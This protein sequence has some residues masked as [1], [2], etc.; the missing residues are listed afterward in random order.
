MPTLGDVIDKWKA[1]D[2]LAYDEFKALEQKSKAM[3]FSMV[4]QTNEAFLTDV[5]DSITYALAEGLTIDDWLTS[6]EA[7]AGSYG[8]G[9]TEAEAGYL[10]T[11]F[12]TAW[13]S[14]MNGGKVSSMFSDER[15]AIAPYW[16]FTAVMDDRTTDECSS[17]NG[18]IFRKDDAD[19]EN[20]IPPLFYNCRSTLIEVDETDLGERDVSAFG[21]DGLPAPPGFDNQLLTV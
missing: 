10:T 8:A 6:F 4:D 9:S 20:Y 7:M 17:L 5:R 1:K 19:A 14:A 3:A 16:E 13:Q 11:V 2:V 21:D 15:K 18:F 12:S